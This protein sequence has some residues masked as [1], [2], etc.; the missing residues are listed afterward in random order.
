MD[1]FTQ[2]VSGAVVGPAKSPKRQ[3]RTIA[4]KRQYLR[5]VLSRIADHPVN[6]I[7]E[8]LPWNLDTDWEPRTAL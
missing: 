8:L 7:G 5:M 1:T 2:S 3:L 4:E 6:R